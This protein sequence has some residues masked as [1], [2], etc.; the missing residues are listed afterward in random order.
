MLVWFGLVSDVSGFVLYFAAVLVNSAVSKLQWHFKYTITYLLP[1]VLERLSSRAPVFVGEQRGVAVENLAATEAR[2][3]PAFDDAD[4]PQ[5][6]RTETEASE[7]FTTQRTV[8][9]SLI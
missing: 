2:T 6:K 9:E 7:D 4:C 1:Y 5:R 8:N 3:V